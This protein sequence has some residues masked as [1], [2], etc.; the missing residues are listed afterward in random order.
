M[1]IEG[2]DIAGVFKRFPIPVVCGAIILTC[3]MSFYFR[4]G[5]LDEVTAKR[6]E[7]SKELKRFKNNVVAAV[8]LDE[9]LAALEKSNQQFLASAIRVTELA[10]NPQIFYNLEK[11]TGVTMV[12]VRQLVT[13]AP[14]KAAADSYMIVPFSVSAEG[15]FKQLL[16]LLKRLEF[17]QQVTRISSASLSPAQNGRLS[18]SFTIDYLG[19]R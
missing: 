6:E 12:D 10:K 8:Q 9:Q 17:G 16:T 3:L 15:E 7:R 11:E 2:K 18:L 4:S 14:G 5:M 1:S 19:L 13:T